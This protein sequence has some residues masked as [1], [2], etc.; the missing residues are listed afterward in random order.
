[1][2]QINSVLSMHKHT[3]THITHLCRAE[4]IYPQERMYVNKLDI[5]CITHGV[6]QRWSFILTSVSFEP[7]RELVCWKAPSLLKKQPERL[8]LLRDIDINWIH[9]E[10]ILKG[11]LQWTQSPVSRQNSY[12]QLLLCCKGLAHTISEKSR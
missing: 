6:L 5:P 10:N 2:R 8:V 1:M 9:T 12:L 3:H 11:L 4:K 7:D